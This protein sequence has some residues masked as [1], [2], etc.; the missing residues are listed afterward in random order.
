MGRAKQILIVCNEDM[1][2]RFQSYAKALCR[3]GYEVVITHDIDHV[4][5]ERKLQGSN[6][7]LIQFCHLL[8]EKHHIPGTLDGAC[9][10]GAI[11]HALRQRKVRTPI[12]LL[13]LGLE[14][15]TRAYHKP[16]EKTWIV[17]LHE[18][19]TRLLLDDCQ[20]VIAAYP[21]STRR[22]TPTPHQTPRP[23]AEA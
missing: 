20:K 13:N 12:L 10:G 6:L 16:Q 21:P 8:T 11:A 5:D 18:R 3:A 22:T 14:E 15:L 19:P 23:R 7:I 9:N 1:L 2:P 17:H 4:A